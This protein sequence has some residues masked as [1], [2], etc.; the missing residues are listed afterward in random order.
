MCLQSTSEASCL[1]H[2]EE[3]IANMSDLRQNGMRFAGMSSCADNCSNGIN[4]RHAYTRCSTEREDGIRQSLVI[5]PCL[6]E[7]YITNAMQGIQ[8]NIMSGYKQQQR[9]TTRNVNADLLGV[10]FSRALLAF[11]SS[12][13]SRGALP[14]HPAF[15]TITICQTIAA[16][17][18]NAC[19][20]YAS[21]QPSI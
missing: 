17:M 3:H 11:P 15:Q 8:E 5:C 18:A 2:Y 13:Q 20:R 9:R 4:S 12:D 14:L 10:Q 1:V 16:S 21:H 19:Y 6:L 7:H